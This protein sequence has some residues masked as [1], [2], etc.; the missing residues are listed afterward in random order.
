MIS[1]LKSSDSVQGTIF[2]DKNNRKPIA[3]VFATE[4][5]AQSQERVLN[6]SRSSTLI[7]IEVGA[8]KLLLTSTIHVS[9]QD[10]NRNKR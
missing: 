5:G 1:W 3:T 9:I 10:I 2:E 7:N 6:A 8:Q 4:K